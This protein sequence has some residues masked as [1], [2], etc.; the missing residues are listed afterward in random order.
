MEKEF[1][2]LQHI[3]LKNYFF[4]NAIVSVYRIDIFDVNRETCVFLYAESRSVGCV[5]L[6]SLPWTGGDWM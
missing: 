5:C 2:I 3:E 1:C 4:E 6:P